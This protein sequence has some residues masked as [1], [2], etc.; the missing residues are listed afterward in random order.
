MAA[1]IK[2]ISFYLAQRLQL[3]TQWFHQHLQPTIRG[4]GLILGLVF[5]DPEAPGKVVSLARER[6]VFILTAGKDAVRLVPSLNIGREEVD[7]A[8]DVLEGALTAL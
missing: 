1:Q 3:L 5:K 8:V 4:R 6:G 2:D 7:L